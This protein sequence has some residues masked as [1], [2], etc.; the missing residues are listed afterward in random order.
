MKEIKALT[1]GERLV[2]EWMVAGLKPNK[3]ARKLGKNPSAIRST[4][5]RMYRKLN[6][7]NCVDATTFAI[8]RGI[9]KGGIFLFWG[10]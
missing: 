3:I 9:V 1:T 8:H 10:S 2:L 5:S 6:T 4:V 7:N